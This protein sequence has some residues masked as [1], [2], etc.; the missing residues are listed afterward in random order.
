MHH[1]LDHPH[2]GDAEAGP[3]DVGVGDPG[4]THETEDVP[5]GDLV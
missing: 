2:D 5:L 4:E 3:H 1:R